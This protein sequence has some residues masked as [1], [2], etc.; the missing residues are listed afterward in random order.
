MKT[1]VIATGF[2]PLEGKGITH[3]ACIC[4]YQ[5][6]CCKH[7]LSLSETLIHHDPQKR[8]MLFIAGVQI[9]LQRDLV[10]DS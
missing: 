1:D 10:K 6:R 3:Q 9:V 5:Q 2:A 8:N 7:G 4:L